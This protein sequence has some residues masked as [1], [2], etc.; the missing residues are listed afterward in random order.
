MTWTVSLGGRLSAARKPRH[1]GRSR[2]TPRSTA[3]RAAISLRLWATIFSRIMGRHAGADCLAARAS[4][5]RPH[6]AQVG[7][8]QQAEARAAGVDAAVVDLHRHPG[9]AATH[10]QVEAAEGPEHPGMGP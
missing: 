3:G 8:Q 10:A 1:A 2:N 6:L 7:A 9:P 5:R 4:S